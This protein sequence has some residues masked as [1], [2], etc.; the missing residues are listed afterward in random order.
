MKCSLSS[1]EE[2][3]FVVL[4]TKPFGSVN[5]VV[6]EIENNMIKLIPTDPYEVSSEPSFWFVPV[7]L[8]YG[9]IL[10]YESKTAEDM[11]LLWGKNDPPIMKAQE[12]MMYSGE[13]DTA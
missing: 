3:D 1:L 12:K 13:R 8:S 5:C 2:Y 9:Q 11:I 7:K 10:G 6:V 4:H